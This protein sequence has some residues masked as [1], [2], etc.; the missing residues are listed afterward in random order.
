M[1]RRE[2]ITLLGGAAT[3]W[4]LVARAQQPR[5]PAIGFLDSRSPD[6]VVSRL[7]AFRQGLKEVGYV[8]G[9]NITIV[10]RWAENKNDRLPELAVDLVQRQ[11]AV[12]LAVGE[13]ATFA[14][15]VAT[16][17]IPT[18]FI[19][20]EDPGR[21]GLVSSLA[22]PGG[23]MTGINFLAAEVTTKRLEFLRQLVPRA[24]RIAVLVNPSD[25]ARAEVTL[26]DAEA[27]ARTMGLEIQVLN[28]DTADEIDS[29]FEKSAREHLD[30]L[31][32]AATPFLSI[33]LVQMAQL[34]AFYRLPAAH[35]QREFT[36]AGGLMSYGSDIPEA[37]R[38][39]GVY[40]G[41]ILKG[42]KPAELPVV[43][44]SKFELAINMRTA[45]MLGLTV[46]T[47]LLATADRVID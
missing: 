26:R 13:P 34:A 38:Q 12:I 39:A 23:N 11:V 18:V 24:T 8:E 28:A 7:I 2:F 29:G 9:E 40:G 1:R 20:A 6:A 21:L 19:L 37:F 36:E 25:A 14:A 33:H 43:Q 31:F 3:A 22:H 30:A 16:T 5:V 44:S 41:R 4:P 42:E 15:K 17:T 46:P 45:R 10:Y 27:A 35:Y 32:V 47:H